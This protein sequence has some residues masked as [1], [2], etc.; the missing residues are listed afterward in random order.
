MNA[1]FGQVSVGTEK[2]YPLALLFDFNAEKSP[3]PVYS[4]PMMKL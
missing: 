2:Q 4:T 3:E 1:P